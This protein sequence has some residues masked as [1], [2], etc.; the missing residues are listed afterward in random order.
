[1]KNKQMQGRCRFWLWAGSAVAG[2]KTC[3]QPCFTLSSPV[4]EAVSCSGRPG[5]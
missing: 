2:A 1:M 3:H 4:S 5:Q